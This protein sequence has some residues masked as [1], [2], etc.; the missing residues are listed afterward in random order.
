VPAPGISRRSIVSANRS[1]DSSAGASL[2]WTN[3]IRSTGSASSSAQVLP[4]TEKCHVST[5]TRAP[6]PASSA[7]A[8][9][10][11]RSGTA[12][13]GLNSTAMVEPASATIAAHRATRVAASAVGATWNVVVTHGAPMVAA[14]SA[15]RSA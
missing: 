6:D 11:R 14:A 12:P 2:N 5:R 3:A 10:S 1:S 7:T 13:I 15:R 8:R 4:P 9:P